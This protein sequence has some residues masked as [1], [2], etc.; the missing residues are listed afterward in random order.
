MGSYCRAIPTML[1]TYV[2]DSRNPSIKFT[3][4]SAIAII[5]SARSQFP[6]ISE[7]HCANGQWDTGID[8]NPPVL[9]SMMIDL[10]DKPDMLTK[11]PEMFPNGHSHLDRV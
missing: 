8:Q 6:A 3:K 2:V 11:C 7:R 10:G 4:L 5:A 1:V 9:I